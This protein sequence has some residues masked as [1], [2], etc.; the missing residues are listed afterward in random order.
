MR[1][2][3]I[4]VLAVLLIFSAL[5]VFAADAED[6]M[7]SIL[8]PGLGQFRTGR[9]SRATVFM[10]TELIALI[11]LGISDI[12][13]DR[14]I[15]AYEKAKFLYGNADYIGDARSYYNDMVEQWDKAEDYQRYRNTFLG[16]AAGVWVINVIDIVWGK[17]AAE[18][19]LSL[20]VQN[21]GFLVSKT[22]S[23]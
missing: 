19:L 21:D 15:E 22:F 17:E 12:Q 20:E 1:R 4:P 7:Y 8:F 5:P 2:S 16:V 9:Y 14:S 13:Y 18:P 23:F 10:G 6:I 11:G 3:I